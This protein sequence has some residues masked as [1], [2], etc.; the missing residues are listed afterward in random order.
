MDI[1][2]NYLKE[3]FSVKS[4]LANGLFSMAD[5]NFNELLADSL[6]GLVK[7]IDLY[8]P[9]ENGDINDKTAYADSV[10]I[11]KADT[12]ELVESDFVIAIIDGE[13][14]D[15]G[16]AAEIG[17]AS[18]MGIPVFAL[19]T[20]IRQYGSANIKKVLAVVNDPIENP[21]MYKNSF[22]VG[23]IKQ[24]GKVFSDVASLITHIMEVTND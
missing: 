9:Q 13:T 7:D 10:A 22:V 17:I 2:R 12:K 20:D 16:V 23:L 11:A 3:R 1:L 14:I 24:N 8:V 4:Y 19:Y 15:S 5:R 18:A 21:F 6:R